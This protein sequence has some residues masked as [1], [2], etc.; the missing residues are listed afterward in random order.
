MNLFRF[1]I[2]PAGQPAHS[3]PAN[4]FRDVAV[5][6]EHEAADALPLVRRLIDK[7]LYGGVIDPSSGKVYDLMV[8]SFLVPTEPGTIAMN[9][10]Q[11]RRLSDYLAM[12]KYQ[13]IRDKTSPFFD[14]SAQHLYQA[15][16]DVS[17]V[18][19]NYTSLQFTTLNAFWTWKKSS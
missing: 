9:A 15:L 18:V 1:P 3:T 6:Y 19:E 11:Q 8:I 7:Q 17:H 2:R 10:D 16:L 4:T 5:T 13:L 14:V 12:Q